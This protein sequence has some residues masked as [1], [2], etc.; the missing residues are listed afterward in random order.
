MSELVKC[1]HSTMLFIMFSPFLLANW[2]GT[3]YLPFKD[4][5]EVDDDAPT[6]I[7][8]QLRIKMR[9][10]MVKWMFQ[11]K[12]ASIYHK[13]STST[14]DCS[15]AIMKLSMSFSPKSCCRNS[16]LTVGQLLNKITWIGSDLINI[17]FGQQPGKGLWMQLQQIQM[18]RVQ[19][20]D[21][22]PYYHPLLQ[23][24]HGT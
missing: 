21:S 4:G 13:L 15:L 24:A 19:T 12:S 5:V 9:I 18:Q 17:Y 10:K 16:L 20:L 6:Q 14:T 11:A 22:G 1:I 7:L 3:P 8:S 23:E 2:V